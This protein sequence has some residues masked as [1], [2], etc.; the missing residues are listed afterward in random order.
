MRRL[1]NKKVIILVVA[2]LF[3]VVGILWYVGYKNKQ[4]TR[5]KE[6][7]YYAKLMTEQKN[8]DSVVIEATKNG[9][10]LE[11]LSG[12]PVPSYKPII[13]STS[14]PVTLRRY[15]EELTKAMLPLSQKH[16]NENLIMLR[17]LDNKDPSEIK[18]LVEARII[19][20][21][22]VN[23]LKKITIPAEAEKPQREII[24][25]LNVI[26]QT[27]ANMEKILQEPVLAL[28]SG[29]LLDKEYTA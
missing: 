10:G 16:E 25:T 26:S 11:T 20:E 28:Q 7:A 22:V 19:Y 5:Q 3:V 14:S 21:N 2:L 9:N 24:L 17:A 8:L 15:G 29:Q 1:P 6:L 23:N 12:V 13:A 4:D 18:K 27:I